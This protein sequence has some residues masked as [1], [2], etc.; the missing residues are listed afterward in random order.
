MKRLSLTAFSHTL[1]LRSPAPLLALYQ[2]LGI[3][4]A[5]PNLLMLYLGAATERQA[6]GPR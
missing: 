4:Q 2:V 6:V 1:A 5:I 3:L